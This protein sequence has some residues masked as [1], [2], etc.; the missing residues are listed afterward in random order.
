MQWLMGLKPRVLMQLTPREACYVKCQQV[1]ENAIGDV[2]N[3]KGNKP[4]G[5]AAEVVQLF[6]ILHGCEQLSLI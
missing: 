4:V 1:C 5:T 6:L 3:D 2:S